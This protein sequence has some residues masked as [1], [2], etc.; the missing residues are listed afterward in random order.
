MPK[1]TTRTT[2]LLRMLKKIYFTIALSITLICIY[3]FPAT[4]SEQTP[5]P[6]K[7][8]QDRNVGIVENLPG[9]WFQQKPA[10]NTSTPTPEQRDTMRKLEALGYMT[11]YE[12]K[13]K[14]AA[15]RW[16]FW[17]AWPISMWT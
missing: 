6:A 12:P 5:R 2:T 11:G 8:K 14:L 10:Q 17:A 9:R 1:M 16:T 13:P 15:W 3:T 7:S 4:G